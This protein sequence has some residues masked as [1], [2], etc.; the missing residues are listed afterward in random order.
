MKRTAIALLLATVAAAFLLSTSSA[1]AQDRVRL[2][3]SGAS[4]PFPLYSAWFKSFSSTSKS[5]SVDYQAKGSGAGIQDFINRTVDFAASDAAMT[6]EEIA[7][8]PGGVQLLPM[9]GGEIA[10]AYNLANVKGLKLPRDVYAG[11]FLGKITKWSDPKIKAANPGASLPDQDITVVRRADSSG[12]TFVFT[13]HLAAVS[14]EWKKGP[15]VGTTVKWAASDKFVASPKNDGVAATLRQTPGSIGYVEYAFA[16]FAK[17]EMASL[18]NKAGQFVA[19]GRQGRRRGAGERQ[20]AGRSE[21]LAA[22][23]GRAA[24]LPDRDLHLA[25][26]L[27]EELGSEEGRGA[28][29][30]G[31]LLPHRGPEGERADGLH[32][33][34]G[35]HYERREKGRREHSMSS[36]EHAGPPG[37]GGRLAIRLGLLRRSRVPRA[38]QGGRLPDPAA[39]RLHPLADRPQGVAGM[40]DYGLG[41]LTSTTWDVGRGHFG[42]LPA[43]WGTLYSSF[44][45]LVIGGFFGVV[46]AIFL[47]QDFLAAAARRGVPHH[48][49]A[50]RRDPERR[51]RPLGHLRR[52]SGDSSGGRL[53]PRASG[54]D[55]ALRVHLERSR[56]PARRAR[57]RHH[58]LA[59][60]GGGVAG[61]APAGAVSSEGSR[62]RHG[63]H[64][65]GG[66][67]EGDAAD[68][69][70]RN[71]RRARSRLRAGPRRDHGARDAHRELEPADA[72]RSS[73]PPTRS[74]RCSR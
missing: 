24:G 18:Q 65:L 44:L 38:G 58:D 7:K 23:S 53:A 33:A 40:R 25:P 51:L 34:A 69:I 14:E 15:G 42:I 72:C 70:D 3:G 1:G 66:D 43:I 16:K 22:R 21:G 8:V 30:A 59:D 47:T 41:F 55:P 62:L 56:A 68:R 49:R 32:P 11:I 31:G 71:L 46:M 6:D 54:L 28:A 52:R 37:R 50:A 13:T 17:L 57:A 12:T 39:P 5:I 61:R 2:T 74:R 67:S 45:A 35:E 9:T 20:A 29:R 36:L 27:Q 26:A 48:G 73:R 63:N 19:P 10:L 60:G 64:A 4:F